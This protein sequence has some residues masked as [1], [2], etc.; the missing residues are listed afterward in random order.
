VVSLVYSIC[1][2]FN[3]ISITS[4]KEMFYFL[5]MDKD[6]LNGEKKIKIKRQIKKTHAY[7]HLILFQF[8]LQVL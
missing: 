6:I 8:P 2:A 4:E 3:D 5:N 7:V 1:T